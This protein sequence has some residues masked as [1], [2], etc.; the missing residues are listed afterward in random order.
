ME[1][2]SCS[3]LLDT[4]SHYYQIVQ[5]QENNGQS[6]SCNNDDPN[7]EF[8]D[9]EVDSCIVDLYYTSLIVE[10]LNDNYL[11]A[12][13]DFVSE[14]AVL[15]TCDHTRNNDNSAPYIPSFPHNLKI[16]QVIHS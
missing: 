3:G 1:G 16:I 8:E 13:S 6:F 12:A 7:L 2:G 15:G 11:N 14:T 9:C 4:S 5:D 10:H